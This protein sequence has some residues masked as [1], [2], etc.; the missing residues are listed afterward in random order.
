MPNDYQ[1]LRNVQINGANYDLGTEDIILRLQH[2]ETL[3]EFSLQDPQFD[4]V[5]VEF[6][7]LPDDMDAFVH[8]LYAFCPDLVDQGTGCIPEMLEL[9]EESDGEM[10][11]YLQDLIEG[12]D[13]K[14]ENCGIE[15]LKRELQQKM[16]VTLWWD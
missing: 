12:V 5:D 16:R 14:D 9:L 6:F 1:A 2:W 3:C 11:A 8:E 4:R 10:P 15:L 13:L 7:R